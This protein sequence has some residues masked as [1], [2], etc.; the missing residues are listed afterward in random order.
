MV[1]GDH[2][3]AF[4]ESGEHKRPIG[5][6]FAVGSPTVIRQGSNLTTPLVKGLPL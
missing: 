4:L 2:S 6:E 1:A 5:L 3:V